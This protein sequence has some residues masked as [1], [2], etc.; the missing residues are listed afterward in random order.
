M[1]RMAERPT[2]ALTPGTDIGAADV[3][4]VEPGSIVR[5][6]DEDGEAEFRIVEAEDADPIADRVSARSPL[7]RA[8]LGRRAG[9]VVRFRAPGGVLGV[10]VVEVSP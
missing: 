1:T 7:G 4:V 10:T 8:L 2:T 3:P 5:V 6:R 9:D